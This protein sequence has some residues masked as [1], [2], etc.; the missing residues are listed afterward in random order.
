VDAHAASH[1]L[2]LITAGTGALRQTNRFPASPAGVHRAVA[3]V[4]RHAE[5]AATLV[6]VDG[7]GSSGAVL[8][9]RLTAAGWSSPKHRIRPRPAD[10]ASAPATPGTRSRSPGRSAAWTARR[11]AGLAPPAP[12]PCYGC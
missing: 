5:H 6:V 9:D 2:A 11:C 10:A 8:T 3:G 1:T 12:A 7:T 4:Q